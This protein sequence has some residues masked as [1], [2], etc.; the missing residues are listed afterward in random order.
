M[1]AQKGRGIG[2]MGMG[3]AGGA[4]TLN[5]AGYPI[6]PGQ[7]P[8]AFYARTQT[9]KF[10]ASCQF[11][12]PEVGSN[13]GSIAMTAGFG[14][15][16]AGQ[17]QTPMYQNNP[18]DGYNS[19]GLPLRN[20]VQLCSFY[21][22]TSE[23]K[24][25][26]TCKWDHSEGP[27]I[28]NT[29]NAYNSRGNPIRPGQPACAFFSKTGTCSFG[30]TCKFDHPEEFTA[31]AQ[32][33]APPPKPMGQQHGVAGTTSMGFPSR[34]GTQSC[35]FYLKTGTCSYS[36]TCKWDHP[37]GAGGSMAGGVMKGRPS[38]VPRAAPY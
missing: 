8:C 26:A 13:M 22:K 1:M 23:C 30:A 16:F 6:R 34:P 24:F 20:G 21:E 27:G 35:Q 17:P 14:G 33:A 3:G 10:G 7:N 9:C 15:Q 28:G 25:G 11:T 5:S 29:A 37:E 4:V 2:M 36:A 18:P 32:G 12:H 38:F 31:L 19:T